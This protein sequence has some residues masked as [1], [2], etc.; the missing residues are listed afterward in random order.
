MRFTARAGHGGKGPVAGAAF[1]AKFHCVAERG[2]DRG[3][4][5]G[6][7]AGTGPA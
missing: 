1:A 4:A 3:K 5:F 7:G 6:A 2:R